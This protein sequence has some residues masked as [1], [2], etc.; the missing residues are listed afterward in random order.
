M[1][2]FRKSYTDGTIVSKC[3]PKSIYLKV[4]SYLKPF[5]TNVSFGID[6]SAWKRPFIVKPPLR[7]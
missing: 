3:S 6:V 1:D 4:T 2:Y 7:V 5:F